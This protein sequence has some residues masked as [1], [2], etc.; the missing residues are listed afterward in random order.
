MHGPRVAICR[1]MLRAATSSAASGRRLWS[2]TPSSAASSASVLW[3]V[4]RR[5]DRRLAQAWRG[6]WAARRVHRDHRKR[7]LTGTLTRGLGFSGSFHPGSA[8]RT[9]APIDR[10]SAEAQSSGRQPSAY[11]ECRLRSH[12]HV[13]STGSEDK[14]ENYC[15]YRPEL[16]S[17]NGTLHSGAACWRLRPKQ[18]SLLQRTIGNQATLRLLAQRIS[19]SSGT[20]NV[21]QLA[22]TGISSSAGPLPYLDQIQRSFGLG[23]DLRQVKAYLGTEA[24]GAARGMGAEAYTTG[25]RVAFGTNPSLRTAAHEAAHVVQQQAGVQLSGGVG[26]AGIATRSTPMRS[27]SGSYREDQARI[28]WPSTRKRRVPR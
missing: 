9:R 5:A 25:G 18:V 16:C 13:C 11:G 4:G 1:P 22:R 15:V 26:Q 24:D 21:H 12:G 20:E 23:H 28:C 3:R 14:G 6:A 8:G 10:G 19:G 2:V 17:Q 7:R 27:R